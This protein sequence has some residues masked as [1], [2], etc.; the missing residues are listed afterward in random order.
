[1]QNPFVYG[2]V[3][4]PAARSAAATSGV[5]SAAVIESGGSGSGTAGDGFDGTS[6]TG[7][8]T[9]TDGPR[10]IN[11]SGGAPKDPAAP[12][13]AVRGRSTGRRW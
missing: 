5:G 1:M 11:E 10:S 8:S 9:R 7:A 13:L 12:C 4:P 6:A 3:V 2:E